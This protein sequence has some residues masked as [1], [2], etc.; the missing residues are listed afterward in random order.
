MRVAHDGVCTSV[1]PYEGPMALPVN[2]M[3]QRNA[4]FV[5]GQPHAAHLLEPVLE[6]VRLGK[7]DSLSIPV[8]VLP[9][10]EAE[11]KFGFGAAKR[12]FVRD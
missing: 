9:W 1:L 11:S 6:L 10:N 7:F 5:T 3:F 4:T 2:A 8:D 12:I